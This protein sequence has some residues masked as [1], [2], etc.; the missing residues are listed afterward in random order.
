MDGHSKS[1]IPSHAYCCTVSA[2][3]GSGSLSRDRLGV[4]D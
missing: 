4:G 2:R 3:N 1:F